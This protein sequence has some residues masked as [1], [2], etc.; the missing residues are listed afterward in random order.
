LR[1]GGTEGV[2]EPGQGGDRRRPGVDRPQRLAEGDRVGV[3]V[4][5]AGNQRPPAEVDGPRPR[6]DLPRHVGTVA[7]GDDRV[8]DDGDRL[9]DGLAR[10]PS[11]GRG[12]W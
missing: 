9:G 12:R 5:D 6:P 8:A 2:L 10:P 4:V 11:S 7:D 1:G 3:V